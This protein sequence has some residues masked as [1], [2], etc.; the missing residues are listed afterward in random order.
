MHE[1][2]K[3]ET[4]TPIRLDKDP[5]CIH[6]P[7]PRIHCKYPCSIEEGHTTI[8]PPF[9]ALRVKKDNL[10]AVVPGP[11]SSEGRRSKNVDK[12]PSE[13]IRPPPNNFD[14]LHCH[15]ARPLHVAPES[16][17]AIGNKESVK[18][19]PLKSREHHKGRE[20]IYKSENGTP[21]LTDSNDVTESL[22][23]GCDEGPNKTFGTRL[24][25]NLH[26]RVDVRVTV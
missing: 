4:L 25:S 24:I 19:S 11:Y 5:E 7:C 26:T 23:S 18:E 1:R 10:T 13:H 15:S 3:E 9:L 20:E 12:H 14:R 17:L 6:H 22:T 16:P 21:H 2:S 8:E